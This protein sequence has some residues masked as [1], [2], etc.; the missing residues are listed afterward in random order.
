MIYP[1]LV[2]DYLLK[3]YV[4]LHK[5]LGDLNLDEIYVIIPGEDHYP[6]NEQVLVFGLDRY[7]SGIA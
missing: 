7:M 2:F 6:L 5:T 3:I 4:V 1:I